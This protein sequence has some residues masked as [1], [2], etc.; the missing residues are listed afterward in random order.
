[1]VVEVHAKARVYSR[2]L[3]GFGALWVTKTSGWVP[4]SVWWLVAEVR[5]ATNAP[6]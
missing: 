5:S 2:H 3:G 4:R 1:M 6:P